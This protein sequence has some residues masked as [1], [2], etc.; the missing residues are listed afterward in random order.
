MIVIKV[1]SLSLFSEGNTQTCQGPGLRISPSN[2]TCLGGFLVYEC[3]VL[4]S[5]T[6]IWDGSA[7]HCPGDR[8][9]LR[10]SQFN[11]GTSD[12][13]NNGEIVGRSAGVVD[14][15]C[16]TSLLNVT[17]GSN[18]NGETVSCT[19]NVDA[20]TTVVGVHTITITTGNYCWTALNFIIHMNFL[21]HMHPNSLVHS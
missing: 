18:M 6:T 3:T 17:V 4:G 8:V 7:F 21:H 12:S 15:V 9:I 1:K 19:H 2:C 11:S 16:F 14:N 5:G 10:H 13:C 20:N